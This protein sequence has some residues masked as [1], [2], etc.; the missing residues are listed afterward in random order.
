VVFRLFFLFQNFNF[1]NALNF[2]F[3]II[4][5]IKRLKEYTFFKLLNFMIIKK[6]WIQRHAFCYIMDDGNFP[7]DLYFVY[8]RG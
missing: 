1:E 6:L 2:P 5:S 7:K 4:R 8:G 3:L